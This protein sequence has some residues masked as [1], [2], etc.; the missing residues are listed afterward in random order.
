MIVIAGCHRSGTSL[1]GHLLHDAGI[2]IDNGIPIN[3][4]VNKNGFFE[5]P[6]VM[7]KNDRL[8]NFYGAKWDNP[9]DHLDEGI[10]VLDHDYDAVKD[11]RFSLTFNAWVWPEDTKL[12]K[13]VRSEAAVVKSLMKRNGFSAFKATNIYRVYNR[14]LNKIRWKNQITVNYEDLLKHKFRKL[15]KFLGLELNKSIVDPSLNHG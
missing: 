10:A 6:D 3:P 8:L 9:P 11:P 15:N 7:V 14:R 1:V 5:S 13:V 2:L 12:I 4:D